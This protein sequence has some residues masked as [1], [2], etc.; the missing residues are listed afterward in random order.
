MVQ[1]E[2]IIN[3]LTRHTLQVDVTKEGGVAEIP[4]KV[5]WRIDVIN[6]Q[7]A[8]VVMPNTEYT[9]STAA[10]A[11]VIPAALNRLITPLADIEL[12]RVTVIAD[13]LAAAEYTYRIKRLKGLA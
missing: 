7:Q 5:V 10:F 13:D 11:L 3:E 1:T 6:G 8:T 9:P 4:S 2:A 12:R